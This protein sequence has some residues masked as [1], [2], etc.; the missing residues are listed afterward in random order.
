M[1]HKDSYRVLD[2]FLQDI[3]ATVD[4]SLHGVPFGGKVVVMA[5]NW[6]QNLL[7]VLRGTRSQVVGAR[8]KSSYLWPSFKIFEIR[9]NLRVPLAS[10]NASSVVGA[11]F[12]E[13]LL[14]VGKVNKPNPLPIPPSMVVPGSDVLD[15]VKTLY[16]PNV[17]HA[18]EN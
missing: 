13:W 7:A 12:A 9:K 6:R 5:G 4:P 3:L 14:N 1:D 15:L 18:L 10:Q 16:P 8:L 2:L 11:N 17:C